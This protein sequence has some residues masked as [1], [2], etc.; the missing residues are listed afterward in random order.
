M[1]KGT[2]A[3][4]RQHLLDRAGR[5]FGSVMGAMG[6]LLL[7]SGLVVLAQEAVGAA[8][9]KEWQKGSRAGG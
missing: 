4:C 2:Q 7:V 6:L 8:M 1:M 9:V 3:R 5:L